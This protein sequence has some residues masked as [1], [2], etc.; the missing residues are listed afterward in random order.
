M[1][2]KK[3]ILKKN[4]S[5][6]VKHPKKG[7]T[8]IKNKTWNFLLTFDGVKWMREKQVKIT[9]TYSEYEFELPRAKLGYI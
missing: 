8:P 6:Q 7:D 2:R 5:A 4:K 9:G 3:S 1:N